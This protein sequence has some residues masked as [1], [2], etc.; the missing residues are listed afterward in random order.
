MQI[1]V[2]AILFINYSKPVNYPPS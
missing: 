1:T 2:L